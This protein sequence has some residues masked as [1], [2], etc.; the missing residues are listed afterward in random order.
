MT[1][2]FKPYRMMVLAL[3]VATSTTTANELEV[4][5]GIGYDSNPFRLN[6]ALFSTS[7]DTFLSTELEGELELGNLSLEADVEQRTYSDDDRA[8]TT[9]FEAEVEYEQQ[10]SKV[11]ELEAGIEFVSSDRSYVSRFSGD[12]FR[13][14]G[15]NAE[16]RYDF[17]RWEP[18]ARVTAKLSDQHR[19]RLTLSHRQQDYDDFT[20]IGLSNLDYD[21]TNIEAQWRYRPIDAFTITPELELSQRDYD[22]RPAADSAGADIPGSTLSY[23]YV[24]VGLRLRYELSDKTTISPRINFVQREDNGGGFYDTDDLRV[25]VSLNHKPAKNQRLYMVLSY[26]DL[27]Y[28]RANTTNIEEDSEAPSRSGWRIR[29]SYEQ[30]VLQLADEHL[31]GFVNLQA[32]DFDADLREYQYDRYQATVGVKYSF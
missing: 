10:L 15:V 14:G 11:V 32:E 20:A 7:S 8:D 26:S 19:L 28:S 29:V 1:S 5:V 18:S 21:Q 31:I 27:E 25:A 24:G 4:E 22:D 23:D 3:V 13:F 12:T 16:D 30:P 9:R 17:T 6:D 2:I